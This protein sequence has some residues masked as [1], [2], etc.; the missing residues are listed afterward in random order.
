MS[1]KFICSAGHLSRSQFAADNCY[2]CRKKR[3]AYAAR[4]W[5][6][7]K[8]M[9]P[10]APLITNTGT[11]EQNRVAVVERMY[12]GSTDPRVNLPLSTLEAC[13]KSQVGLLHELKEKGC[14]FAAPLFSPPE[15]RTRGSR[16]EAKK[17]R[18]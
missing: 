9:E 1:Y 8:W 4:T 18:R 16:T 7:P 11:S 17:P 3:S 6:M 13:V 14:L 10:F 12:N 5:R 2:H 15:S